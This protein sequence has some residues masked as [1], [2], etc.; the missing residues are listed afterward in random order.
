MDFD[1]ILKHVG[2]FGAYQRKAYALLC[3]IG[4][5]TAFQTLGVV[6]WAAVP[7]HI[8]KLPAEQKLANQ[9]HY[10]S[11]VT[12]ATGRSQ[13]DVLPLSEEEQC[14]LPT[15]SFGANYTRTPN[16]PRVE[17]RTQIE[18]QVACTEWTYNTEHHGETIVS[19]VKLSCHTI[20]RLNIFYF[21]PF[22]EQIPRE[23][24]TFIKSSWRCFS[25]ISIV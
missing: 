9:S 10:N 1:S 12:F 14:Y 25:V 4:I 18:E 19:K 16:L 11:D 13:G 15:P 5:S 6:F 7:P 17:A 22:A 24:L 8:C 23:Q 3:F 21:I 20:S 2:E